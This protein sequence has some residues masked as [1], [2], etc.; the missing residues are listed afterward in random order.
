MNYQMEGQHS[1]PKGLQEYRWRI[2]ILTLDNVIWTP[3]AY[4]KVHREFDNTTIFLSYLQWE[5]FVA[6]YL[7][8]RCMCL[9]M[10]VQGILRPVSI[11]PS[12]GI[13]T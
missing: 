4:H 13:G 10:Y 11:V 3:Y 12:E 8:E 5:C 6:R 9:F 2:N 1:N 7:S